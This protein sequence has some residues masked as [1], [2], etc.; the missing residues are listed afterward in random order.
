MHDRIQHPAREHPVDFG[1]MAFGGGLSG[2]A[3]E[4]AFKR[5]QHQR[6]LDAHHHVPL[7]RFRL[8]RNRDRVR[9]KLRPR[10]RPGVLADVADGD[11]DFG[12]QLAAQRTAERL[13]EAVERAQDTTPELGC[14]LRRLG[15][16][17]RSHL[18]HG[19]ARR[20]EDRGLLGL[21][22]LLDV[23]DAGLIA[24]HVVVADAHAGVLSS[25]GD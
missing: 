12:V 9:R 8:D 3:A 5:L 25:A 20:L 7:D 1:E 15:E 13:A 24:R 23:L 22:D 16:V 10:R 18:I 14:E 17:E 4:Q 19:I 21:I 11:L 6:A 2:L